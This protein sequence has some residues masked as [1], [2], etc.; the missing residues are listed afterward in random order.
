MEDFETCEGWKESNC[1]GAKLEFTD[2][3]S[4]CK[5][6]ADTSCSDCED[7]DKCTNENKTTL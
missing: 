1:C 5:E 3:C 4:D 6:H 7:F 2:I